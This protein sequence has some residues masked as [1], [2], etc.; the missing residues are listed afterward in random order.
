[1]MK[2]STRLAALLLM[3]AGCATAPEPDATV[4]SPAVPEESAGM[5]AAAP[6]AG[7]GSVTAS[8]TTAAA[9]PNNAMPPAAS[10]MNTPAATS[11]TPMAAASPT[12]TAPQPSAGAS[13]LPAETP[14][15]T[16][17][18]ES[19]PWPSDCE[20][21]YVFRAHAKP[22]AD[23]AAKYDVAA[24]SQ[25]HVS[26]FFKAPWGATPVQLLESRASVDNKSV[27]HHWN[28]Y[29]FNEAGYRDGE[30]RGGNGEVTPV[31]PGEA[32]VVT[33]ALGTPPTLE[34]PDDVGLR[35][36][37]G[38]NAMLRLELHYFNAADAEQSDASSVE[39][40]VTSKPRSHAAAGHWL[41]TFNIFLPPHARTD[42]VSKCEP[43]A[44][45][46][47]VHILALA[48][49]MHRTGVHS[50]IMLERAS[51]EQVTLHDQPFVFDEQ[52]IYD[53]PG[54]GTPDE[55]IAYPGDTITTTCTYQND[56]DDILTVGENT[57][58]EMC[59]S[60]VFAWPLGQLVNDSFSQ[61]IVPGALPDV[62]CL[63]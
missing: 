43:S 4:L 13:E 38:E 15:M 59:I 41:G 31:V 26:F 37:S 50:K 33:G 60:L 30:I 24:G 12:G 62:N 52:R 23:D 17:P 7:N 5:Q 2:S 18:A 19:A 55:R 36:P 49:H 25:F 32:M 11:G 39:I 1:M 16:Q 42:L 28:L 8:S 61:Y 3:S 21:R 56:G 51:G 22:T 46:E 29:A 58:N 57:E 47:P 40:C 54:Y 14:P 9:A 35:V 44:M 45:T 20:H 48:P 27:V 34:M 6:V 10:A 63:N 53:L